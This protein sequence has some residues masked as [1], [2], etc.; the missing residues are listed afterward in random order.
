MADPF[1]FDMMNGLGAKKTNQNKSEQ[2]L[3]Y[4]V[5][6]LAFKDI[7]KSEVD[8][9]MEIEDFPAN[10][11]L[12]PGMRRAKIEQEVRA[13]ADLTDF[14]KWMSLANKIMR[15]EGLNYLEK[16]EGKDLLSKLDELN[17]NVNDLDL[18]EVTK[19]N[20]EEA[21]SMPEKERASI[22]K[23]GIGKYK[24][25][26]LEDTLAIFTFLTAIAEEE[27]NYWFRL[28]LVAQKV[29]KYALAIEALDTLTDLDP[30]FI[31]AYFYRTKCYL[32]QKMCIEAESELNKAKAILK[33]TN[34]EEKWHEYLIE[35]EDLLVLLK[36]P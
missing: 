32:D 6:E 34:E 16:S 4:S 15:N 25:G 18:R 36:A 33:T 12:S 14:Q 11:L 23:I 9:L 20:L 3:A 21:L 22:L 31:E 24:E 7:I 26:M 1:L 30:D 13:G 17:L 28:A 10:S 27:P 5:D 8:R 35:I 2:S 19:E 29:G